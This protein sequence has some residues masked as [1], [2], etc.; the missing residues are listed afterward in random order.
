VLFG[1]PLANPLPMRHLLGSAVCCLFLISGCASPE[2]EAPVPVRA[3]T[4]SGAQSTGN[5]P[6]SNCGVIT[7]AG[8]CVGPT[9]RNCAEGKLTPTDCRT[10][11][12]VCTPNVVGATCELPA[13]QQKS[14]G[15]PSVNPTGGTNKTPT[16]PTGSSSGSGS[17]SS[18]WCLLGIFCVGGSTTVNS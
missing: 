2:E 18:R 8:A 13:S 5:K 10:Q 6:D 11:G 1:A 4:G 16:S 15:T 14:I 9:L 7:E 3:R 17:G 12:K